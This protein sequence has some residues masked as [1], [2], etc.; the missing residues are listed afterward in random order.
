MD[1]NDSSR[2]RETGNKNSHEHSFNRQYNIQTSSSNFKLNQNCNKCHQCS[3][4]HILHNVSN[5][6]K[7]NLG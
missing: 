2:F 3:V 5:R 1:L 6:Y 7:L 4:Q